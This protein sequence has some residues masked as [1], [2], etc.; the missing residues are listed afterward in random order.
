MFRNRIQN[1]L[2]DDDNNWT[3]SPGE[4]NNVEEEAAPWICSDE[5]DP[6]QLQENSFSPSLPDYFMEE[7]YNNMASSTADPQQ[8]WNNDNSQMVLVPMVPAPAPAPEPAP[9]GISSALRPISS[10]PRLV[11][12][13]QQKCPIP[14]YQPYREGRSYRVSKNNTSEPSR[15]QQKPPRSTIAVLP[16]MGK[17]LEELEDNN[18]NNEDEE[19]EA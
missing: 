19:N 8:Q 11:V 18:N 1:T 12:V 3:P 13:Q 4:W 7:F 14:L 6:A 9:A 10:N 5:Y 17:V 15:R 2:C 16:K